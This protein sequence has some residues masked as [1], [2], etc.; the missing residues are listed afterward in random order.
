MAA[1]RRR[2]LARALLLTSFTEFLGRGYDQVG[3]AV[4]ATNPTGAVGLYESLGMRRSA[5]VGLLRVHAM[6]ATTIRE[7]TPD[8]AAAVLDLVVLCDIAEI[9]EPDYTLEDVEEDLARATQHGWVGG[10]RWRRARRLLLGG[11]AQQPHVDQCRRDGS[12]RR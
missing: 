6:T 5:R 11:T 8:D 12:A 7:V 4:D 1:F 3:L 9:G 2:G 10:R